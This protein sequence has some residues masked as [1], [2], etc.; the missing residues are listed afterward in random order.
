[1]YQFNHRFL[2]ES[3]GVRIHEN[4]D[5]YPAIR[6]QR[7]P[8]QE[9]QRTEAYQHE[10]TSTVDERW[11]DVSERGV[12]GPHHD[13]ERVESEGEHHG[14]EE[15][16]PEGGFRKCGHAL[17]IGDE[18]Q[19]RSVVYHVRDG[20]LHCQRRVAK[21]REHDGRAEDARDAIDDA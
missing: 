12:D 16:G 21:K 14:E 15:E 19:T 2:P 13:E 9:M 10:V 20:H 3:G 1:M 11:R 5:V 7:Q 6:H 18:Y 8:Q 17:D 4:H